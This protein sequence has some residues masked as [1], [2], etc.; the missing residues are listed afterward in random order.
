MAESNI[1]RRNWT[2]I[3]PAEAAKLSR[4]ELEQID[5]PTNE[6]GETCPWPWEPQQLGGAPMGQYHCS[7]CGGMEIAGLP[8]SD[9]REEQ[10]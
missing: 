2:E 8:H 1:P 7:Y 4:E 5:R 10:R 3:E 9:W 6:I